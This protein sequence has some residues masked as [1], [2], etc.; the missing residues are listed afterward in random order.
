MTPTA[1]P[2]GGF[3]WGPRGRLHPLGSV[4][5][6]VTA[7]LLINL[8]YGWAALALL[9]NPPAGADWASSRDLLIVAA[10]FLPIVLL[11]T[12]FFHGVLDRLPWGLLWQPRPARPRRALLAAGLAGAALLAGLVLLVGLFGGLGGVGAGDLADRGPI[13]AALVVCLY[14][15]GFL[16]QSGTEEVVFRGYLLRRLGVWGGGGAALAGSALLFGGAHGFNP[17]GSWLPVVNTVLIGLLL[18]LVR[19]RHS[20]LAAV[21]VHAGWNFLLSLGQVPVSGFAL[22]GLVRLE[23]RG[24]ALLSGGGYGLEGSLVTTGLIAIACAGALL[25]PGGRRL[26]R[27]WWRPARRRHSPGAAGVAPPGTGRDHGPTI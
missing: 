22:P 18:G 20:L 6:F 7:G 4:A 5:L 23:L 26:S 19:V 17:A 9:G 27:S 15:L 2:A 3:D 13:A 11:L 10:G 14:A 16:I 1:P 12:A 8:V 25:A 24:G 21:G